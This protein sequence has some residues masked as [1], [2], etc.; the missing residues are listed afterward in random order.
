MEKI[1]G[2]IQCIF[3]NIL[4]Q[5]RFG[6]GASSFFPPVVITL[7]V[8]RKVSD[9]VEEVRVKTSAIVPFEEEPYVIEV[10][11]TQ[12]WT[13]SN[14]RAQPVIT[15]G[16]EL[17]GPHWDQALNQNSTDGR[18]KHWGE[19]LIN[20]WP[21]REGNLEERLAKFLHCIIKVQDILQALDMSGGQANDL[22]NPLMQI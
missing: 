5:I 7:P 12:T 20:I 10:S 11:V 19:G 1:P 14:T 3:R 2:D 17:F 21:A 8:G 15:W 18:K 9:E 16:V 4:V 6:V 22:G 13:G